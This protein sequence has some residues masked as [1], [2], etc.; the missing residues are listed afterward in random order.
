MRGKEMNVT[1]TV[2]EKIDT[3]SSMENVNKLKLDEIRKYEAE[4]L[5]I[6]SNYNINYKKKKKEF[7]QK[8]TVTKN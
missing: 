3:T 5:K 4:K 7:A 8:K 1:M 2:Q 6:E